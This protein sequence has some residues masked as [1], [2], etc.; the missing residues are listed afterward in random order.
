MVL[1]GEIYNFRELRAEL[2]ARGHRF[3]T[4]S[5]TEAIVHAYE[6]YGVGCV[7]RLRGMFAFALWD[8]T[9]G[10]LLLARDRVGKKPLYYSEDA[11]RF[12]FASE[13]KALL[14]DPGRKRAV[15]LEAINDY[16][17]FGCVQAPRTILEGVAQLLPAHY[18][19]WQRGATQ[20][21]EYWDVPQEPI[22][23]R[24]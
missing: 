19:V 3:R 24:S 4:R 2:E 15:K 16:L 13:L 5:D 21:F 14:Q 9:D 22:T 6:E 23:F 11:E 7:A 17:S 12:V 1:N 20:V 18:L 10:R 8:E